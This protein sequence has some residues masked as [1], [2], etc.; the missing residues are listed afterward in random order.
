V[1]FDIFCLVSEFKPGGN[2]EAMLNKT[3]KESKKPELKGKDVI[4]IIQGIGLSLFYL[5]NNSN[6]HIHF[7]SYIAK[8]I[9]FLHSHGIAHLDLKPANIVLEEIEGKISPCLV[10]FGLSS[11]CSESEIKARG[12]KGFIAPEL[13]KNQVQD[14]PQCDIYSF[15]VFFHISLLIPFSFPFHFHLGN[16]SSHH[17]KTI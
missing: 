7:L 17:F 4:I 1:I 5:K 15:G 8:G 2:L 16:S 13:L 12:T 6:I 3:N 9:G 11:F 10:D 14:P